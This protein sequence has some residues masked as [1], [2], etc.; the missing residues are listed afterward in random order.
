MAKLK[1][2]FKGGLDSL[3]E[4]SL[5]ITKE[6]VEKSRMEREQQKNAEANAAKAL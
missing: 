2:N 4:S 6:D 1:K 5:G 3:I